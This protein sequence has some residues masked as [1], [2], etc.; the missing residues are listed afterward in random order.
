MPQNERVSFP[1]TIPRF[2][3]HYRGR[4][5]IVLACGYVL[6]CRCVVKK[7]YNVMQDFVAVICAGALY[8]VSFI[9]P[10]SLPF[11]SVVFV[12]RLLAAGGGLAVLLRRLWAVGGWQKSLALTWVFGAV[13]W[14]LALSG[15]HMAF[16]VVHN[17]ALFLPS[18]A[19]LGF[20]FAF[21]PAVFCSFARLLAGENRELFALLFTLGFVG[22]GI[23]TSHLFAFPL[24][25][26]YQLF[27]LD[28]S[29]VAL[30]FLQLSRFVGAHVL[31]VMLLAIVAFAVQGRWRSNAALWA[32]CGVGGA[33]GLGQLSRPVME[34]A[35]GPLSFVLLQPN[36]PQAMKME[37]FL[38]ES[39]AHTT[40][41]IL[42]QAQES[43]GKNSPQLIV[44]P[45][46]AFPY[47]LH[48]P[49]E[50]LQAFR[51]RLNL[52]EHLILGADY[53]ASPAVAGASPVWHNS[54]FVLTREGLSERYDKSRLLPFGEYV[55]FR[56]IFP[57]IFNRIL[58]GTDCSPGRPHAI[59]L[60]SIG[61]TFWPLVCSESLFRQHLPKNARFMLEIFN[62]GWFGASLAR[63]HFAAVRVRAVEVGKPLVRCG[64][65]GLSGVI[66]AR[67]QVRSLLP[68]YRRAILQVELP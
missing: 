68:L 40:L 36:I 59:T 51:E 2:Q 8:G 13:A 55:P 52:A 22:G 49:A 45:E 42:D 25:L 56:G 16:V 23:L 7:E 31:S 57:P 32:L 63:L 27:A 35:G 19:L 10:S 67:G 60:K 11:A 34:S 53:A 43:R 39:I 18:L 46:T 9:F 15:L 21:A 17:A 66:T 28:E 37:H 41:Q 12:L 48:N 1:Y 64:N 3:K 38:R 54:L 6:L 61:V 58:G 20:G 14:A 65:S 30:V 5:N 47:V 62:D 50:E 26:P 4:N 29:A 44:L 24:G 33:L